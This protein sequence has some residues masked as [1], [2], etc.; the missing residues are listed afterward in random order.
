MTKSTTNDDK[1]R[2]SLQQDY[3]KL[4][5]AVTQAA[6]MTSTATWQRHYSWMTKQIAEMKDG[7]PR[8][9]KSDFT[10][11]QERCLV[12]E[13]CINNVRR[14]VDE[15]NTFLEGLDQSLWDK[16]LKME[17]TWSAKGEAGLQKRPTKKAA[18]TFN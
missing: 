10:K 17:G 4:C 13:D 8:M 14:P 1:Q 6:T 11:K 7:F 3:D 16:D 9:D 2:D 18:F 5:D 15:L 12:F